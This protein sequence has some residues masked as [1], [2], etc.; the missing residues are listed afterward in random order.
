[1]RLLVAAAAGAA[2]LLGASGATSTADAAQV[3]TWQA[4]PSPFR[5]TFLLGGGTSVAEAETSG[6]P[7]GRLSY[8][9]QDGSFHALADLLGTTP[10]AQGTSYRVATDEPGRTATVNVV[11]TGTGAR[12][13]LV[14][15]PSTGVVATFEAFAAGPAE[16]FLGGGERPG[17]LDLRGQAFTVKVAYACQNTMPA[18]FYLS[19]AGYG[20][21]LRTSAIASLGF[22]GST[23]SSACPGGAPPR[24]PL[25]DGLNVVQLCSKTPA[26]AYDVYGG[27]PE[28]IVSSYTAT[29]GRPQLPPASQF[30]LIKW[31]DV[32][33]RAQL[34]ED[35]D[36]LRALHI[37][38]GWVLLDNPWESDFCYGQMTFDATRFPDPAGMI[39]QIHAKGVR[40]MLWI[41]PLIRQQ[42]CPAPSQYSQSVL[43]GTGGKAVTIDLTDPGARATFVASLRTLIGDGVDGFKADRGDEIDLELE[44]LAG[45]AG[46]TLHNLY[47]LLY[48][49]A[50]AQAIGDAGRAGTFA[51]LVRAG[52][53]GSAAT[54]P[55]FWGGDQAGSFTGLQQAIHDGLSA[56]VAGYAIWGSDTGG[57]GATESAEVL[58]RWAQM[59]AVSPVFEVG[60]TGGNGTFWQYGTPTVD[61]FRDAAVLHYELFPYLYELARAAHATG[62]PILRP[63]A[64]EYPSDPAAWTSDLELLVG[65]DLLAA[66]VTSPAPAGAHG[67]AQQPVY[68]PAGSWIDLATG[69]VETGGASFERTTPLT[70]LPVYLRAGAAIPFSARAPQLWPRPWPTD[71][72]RLRGRGGWLIAP[73]QRAT[74]AR[75]TEFGSIAV[76]SAHRGRTAIDVRHALRETQI[77]IATIH[78]P[79]M[80]RIAGRLV[81]RSRSLT[82]LQRAHEGWIVVRRPFPAV[83]LKLAPRAGGERVELAVR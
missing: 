14:L 30:E 80:V 83:A 5:L 64:L 3:I 41:S 33:E 61:A 25:A 77:L 44:R 81:A 23:S 36:K 48:A 4:A 16:H 79:T 49:Q 7:G 1:M 55:G 82:Q 22:P 18:P 76:T 51:T 69:T 32:A 37:P 6:G 56:G 71:A 60:G 38:I 24:C 42:Y 74:H 46:V 65:H 11:H 13:S 63:L 2:L 31:R 58:V 21:S 29:I 73:A 43:F 68:L 70:E 12:V 50:I 59:S 19:S 34:F 78:V 52:A 57:Y 72:L 17:A 27:T 9:L 67:T 28:A 10:V 15:Q 53:P 39:R 54:L 45:G 35:I 20:I 62:V 47:P 26:L 66:P 75:T 8:R 40:F